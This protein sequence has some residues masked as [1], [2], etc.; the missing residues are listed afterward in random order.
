MQTAVE[1]ELITVASRL[2]KA[3]TRAGYNAVPAIKAATTIVA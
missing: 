3:A 1:Q 2:R